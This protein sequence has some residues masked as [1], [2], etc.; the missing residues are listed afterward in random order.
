MIDGGETPLAG[1]MVELRDGGTNALVRTTLTGPC[2]L[3]HPSRASRPAGP[4]RSPR[5][6]PTGYGSSLHPATVARTGGPTPADQAPDFGDTLAELAGTVFVDVD[7]DGVRDAGEP[8]IVGATVTLDGTDATGSAVTATTATATDGSYRF[9]DLL[10]GTHHRITETQPW[11][12]L[13]GAEVQARSRR[14]PR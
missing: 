9:G 8:G 4:T 1:V 5:T 10:A 12:H 3:L 11:G 14:T 7:R 6:D 13:D 2:R